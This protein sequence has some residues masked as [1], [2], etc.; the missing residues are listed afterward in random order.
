MQLFGRTCGVQLPRIKRL[1][2]D[3][4]SN[5]QADKFIKMNFTSIKL[6]EREMM[7]EVSKEWINHFK[8]LNS[9][10]EDKT[11]N[12]IFLEIKDHSRK[13][14]II[15]NRRSNSSIS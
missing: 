2:W 6:R 8:I 9:M 12:E 15:S 4:V 5:N 1:K 10:M 11:R 3:K 14:Q 7:Q 13:Y